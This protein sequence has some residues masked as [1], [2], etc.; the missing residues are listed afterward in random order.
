MDNDETLLLTPAAHEPLLRLTLR[1]PAE[2][3]EQQVASAS[4]GREGCLRIGRDERADWSL[5]DRTGGISRQHCIIRFADDAFVLDD[6]S[7]NGTFVNGSSERLSGSYRLSDGDQLCIG[8]YLIAVQLSGV[9]ET[10][11][12]TPVDPLVPTA[13]TSAQPGLPPPAGPATAD[14]VRASAAQAETSRVVVRR[15][16][17]PAALFADAM[18]PPPAAPPAATLHAAAEVQPPDDGFTR[19]APVAR[20]TTTPPAPAAPQAAGADQQASA[21]STP[22][23]ATSTAG[24]GTPGEPAAADRVLAGIAQG[25]G[26]SID[27]LHER[28]PAVL[29]EQLGTLLALLTGELRQL[30]A[31]RAAAL[32]EPASVHSAIG[33]SNPLAILPSSEEALRVLFGPPRRAYLTP[34]EAFAGSLRELAQHLAQTNAA[35]RSATRLLSSELAPAAIEH[36]AQLDKGFSQ[37]LGARKGKLW[38]IYCERWNLRPALQPERPLAS[39]LRTFAETGKDDASSEEEP[40]GRHDS[41][42]H[43]RD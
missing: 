38:E 18:P 24:A 14:L 28:D 35:I 15:G 10:A 20:K 37:L 1:H 23:E 13:G 17:D 29:G 6:T 41:K 40:A 7:A 5:A 43:L 30:L 3:A 34:H 2:L 11:A 33:G 27:D 16:G 12:E 25:L 8:P 22:A 26:L 4:L 21:G 39:F 42:R 36:A 9:A 19:L 32:D 31:Q